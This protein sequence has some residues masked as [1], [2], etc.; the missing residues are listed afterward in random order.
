SRVPTTAPRQA[1]E[2]TPLAGRTHHGAAAEGAPTSGFTSTLSSGI[3]L[4]RFGFRMTS[5]PGESRPLVVLHRQPPTAK[6][7]ALELEPADRPAD[8]APAPPMMAADIQPEIRHAPSGRP[9]G[10]LAVSLRLQT[11]VGLAG[12]E[13]DSDSPLR[14]D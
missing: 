5:A 11:M 12:T 6:M 3:V 8:P 10:R 1:G 9:L 2:R 14:G 13:R 7:D 4:P